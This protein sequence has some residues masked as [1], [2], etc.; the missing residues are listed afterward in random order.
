MIGKLA[1]RDCGTGRL[2]KPQIYQNR[3]RGQNR[4][5]IS[6]SIRTSIG[7]IVVT[8]N[9][10]DKIEVDLDMNRVTEEDTSEEI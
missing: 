3:S 5:I 2:F 8:V 9:N 10:T 4:F 6:V 1:T 7:Q